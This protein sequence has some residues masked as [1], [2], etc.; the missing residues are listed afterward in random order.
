[1][2][3]RGDGDRDTEVGDGVI[4]WREGKGAITFISSMHKFSTEENFS[5]KSGLS[6]S[7][8]DSF[9]ELLY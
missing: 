7:Q 3:G 9:S 1:M 6:L 5:C 4:D 2:G 8:V